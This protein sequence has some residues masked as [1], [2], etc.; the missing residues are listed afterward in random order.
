MT[1][2]ECRQKAE[3]CERLARIVSYRPDRAVLSA[4][5]QEWRVKETA[6]RAVEARSTH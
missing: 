6:A 5:K 1:S 4:Q 2:A 3:D